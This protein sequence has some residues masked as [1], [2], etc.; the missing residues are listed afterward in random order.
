VRG[1]KMHWWGCVVGGAGTCR[2]T[3]VAVICSGDADGHATGE[4][5]QRG[6][7]AVHGKTLLGGGGEE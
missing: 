1:Q 5:S 3:G 4:V 2:V 6:Q 7:S